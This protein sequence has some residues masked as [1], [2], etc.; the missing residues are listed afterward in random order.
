MGPTTV[1][2]VALV[3][4]FAAIL[5][6]GRD[7]W[8]FGDDWA[9]LVP[10]NDG[11]LLL[12]H[13]G[14]WNLVPAFVFPLVRNWLGL[15]S[16]LPFLALSVI[17]H[18]LVAHLG[19]R[20]LRRIGVNEWVAVTL[21]VFVMLLGGAAENL[22]WAFQFGFMGAIA[23]GLAVVLLFDQPKLTWRIAFAIVGCSVLA[24]MFSGTAI[25]VLAAA[26][27]VGWIRHGFL[28]TAALLAPTFLTY[29]LW[30]FLLAR[31]YPTPNAGIESIADIGM[32][33]LFGAAMY[34]GGLGRAFPLIVL[35]VI[36]AAIAGAWFFVTVKRKIL[37]V[38]APAYALVIGSVVFVLLTSYSRA[39]F[40][41]SAAAAQRYAYVTIVLL[42]PA[43]GLLF[44]WLAL[45]GPRFFVSV[46]VFLVLMVGVN[47]VMLVHDAGPQADRE[48]TSKARIEKALDEVIESPNDPDVL[49]SMPDPQW[50]PDVRG[51]DLLWLYEA[52]Q[53]VPE[54][55]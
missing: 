4:S 22:L 8:F 33:L 30:Y 23:F 6:I 13:M 51:S 11:A 50:S 31:Q 26:A 29:L 9:I 42:V 45:R 46:I 40:G 1:H 12:P 41:L 38:A 54:G 18:L 48:A 43:F 34:A 47:T 15:G 10:S 3:V 28:R 32:V 24:P 21:S 27:I 19:W 14:H 39:P 53:L 16:Y 37:T 55:R 20:I 17:M 2:Y 44:T 49:N 5:W 35:G 36:P 52:G 25:P 7:Q